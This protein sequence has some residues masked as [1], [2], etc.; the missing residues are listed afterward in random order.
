MDWEK[1]IEGKKIHK[2]IVPNVTGMGLKDALYLL[3]QCGL[4]V[5]I[6]GQGKVV[7]QSLNPGQKAV[8]G[9]VITIELRS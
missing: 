1:G 4:Y 5:R 9:G 8:P 6:E 3:E 2:N 7:K